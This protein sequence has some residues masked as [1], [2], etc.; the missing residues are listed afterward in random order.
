MFLLKKADS[1]FS[2]IVFGQI[3]TV[4]TGKQEK[5]KYMHYLSDL[6]GSATCRAPCT[7]LLFN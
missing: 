4:A 1:K 5:E 2:G 3:L 7:L 6:F